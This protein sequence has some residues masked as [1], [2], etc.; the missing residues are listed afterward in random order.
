MTN[1]ARTYAISDLH[2]GHINVLKHDNRPF[3]DIQEHDE[4]QISGILETV[5]ERGTLWLLGDLGRRRQDVQELLR[6]LRKKQLTVNLVR[7]NHDDFIKGYGPNVK[8]WLLN[9]IHDVA[10][11]RLDGHKFFLSHYPHASWRGSNHGS[12]HIHGHCHGN[13]GFIAPDMRRIDVGTNVIGYKPI[14]FE[15]IVDK[16]KDQPFNDHHQCQ[17]K[18]NQ[19][20]STESTTK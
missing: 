3:R 10:Y 11:F 13:M 5:P 8:G 12:F 15:E 20:S 18:E 1:L 17:Q 7:G 14:S 2:L 19:R 6:R 4:A 9:R 16:L